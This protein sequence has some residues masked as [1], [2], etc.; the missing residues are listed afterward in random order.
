MLNLYVLGHTDEL[1]ARLPALAHIVP[2]ALHRM[3]GS[4]QYS[5][6]RFFRW[7]PRMESEYVGFVSC[8][9]P[10]K[11]PQ[12][13]PLDRLHE[14]PLSPDAVYAASPTG[15]IDWVKHSEQVHPGMAALIEELAAAMNIPLLPKAPTFW[16]SNFI[17]HRGVWESYRSAF[18]AGATYAEEQWGV[19]PPFDIGKYQPKRKFGYVLERVMMAYF[20]SRSDL[21]IVKI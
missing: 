12:C 7:P 1:L 5:E 13:T 11:F 9:L 15:G 20:A 10:E 2:V 19:D 16:T 8:R 17:L 3:P 6:F 18:A 21:K 4:G 14:L